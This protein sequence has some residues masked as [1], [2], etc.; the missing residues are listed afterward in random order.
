MNESCWHVL[1]WLPVVLVVAW[2]SGCAGTTSVQQSHPLMASAGTPDG[3]KVYFLRPD[4]GFRGVMDKPLTISLGGSE[5]LA[6]AKGQYTLLLLKPGTSQMKLDFHT[7]AGPSNTMTPVSA[8]F[9][10]TLSPGGTQYLVFDLVPRGLGAGSTFIPRQVP[11]DRA[12]ELAKGLS[13]VG[14]AVGEPL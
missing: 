2:L 7:V 9:P 11:R 10:L 12:I 8:T 14:A 4:P 13:A 3:A 5:I 6:L 1:K